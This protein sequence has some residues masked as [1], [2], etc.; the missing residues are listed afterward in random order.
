MCTYPHRYLLHRHA[1]KNHIYLKIVGLAP[2]LE[3]KLDGVAARVWLGDGGGRA[4]LGA[5]QGG[6]AETQN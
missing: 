1:I 2:P 5:T 3:L 4:L 6:S